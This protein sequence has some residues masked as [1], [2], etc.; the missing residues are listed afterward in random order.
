MDAER[1]PDGGRMNCPDCGMP[2]Y[3][4]KSRSG[5]VRR[6]ECDNGHRW[7]AK[8][9]EVLALKRGFPAG[10]VRLTGKN[11]KRQSSMFRREIVLS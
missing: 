3:I 5:G 8:D 6:Y 7:T 1:D 4:I 11:A 10:G 2:G 9:G